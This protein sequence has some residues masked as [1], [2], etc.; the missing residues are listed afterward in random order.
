M[1]LEQPAND[2]RTHSAYNTRVVEPTAFYPNPVANNENDGL[3]KF[4][5]GC[6]PGCLHPETASCMST[7]C[8]LGCAH[9]QG[10]PLG[11]AGGPGSTPP[12][13]RSSTLL[14][15]RGCAGLLTATL[16]RRPHRCRGALLRSKAGQQTKPTE[17]HPLAP[18]QVSLH[19]VRLTPHMGHSSLLLLLEQQS[20]AA[21]GYRGSCHDAQ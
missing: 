15:P 14:R 1:Q 11:C 19:H 3:I 5:P 8:I 20:G 4:P 6:L 7:S 9:C 12:T 17:W 10:A 16:P 18:T 2:Q 13:C 21:S